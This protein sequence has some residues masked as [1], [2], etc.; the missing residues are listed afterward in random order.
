[1]CMPERIKEQRIAKGLT[2]EE[3]GEKLGL[4]KSA[5]A[6]YENGRVENIKRSV[7]KKMAKALECSPTYLL[8]Y[9][10]EYTIDDFVELKQLPEEER[11]LLKAYRAASDDRK[12]AIRLLLGI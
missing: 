1:M 5:I 6:K 2:Q 7:I 3:L 4:K 11:E 10:A 12:E 8:G 9:D